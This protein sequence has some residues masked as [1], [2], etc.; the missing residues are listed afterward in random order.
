MDIHKDNKFLK[1]INFK[2]ALFLEVNN[3]NVKIPLLARTLCF[4]CFI[5]E[6]IISEIK[7]DHLKNFIKSSY[8]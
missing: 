8:K 5:C 3:K 7:N 6:K 1:Q 2:V 4:G